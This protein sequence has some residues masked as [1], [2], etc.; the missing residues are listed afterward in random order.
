M[1][2]NYVGLTI[3]TEVLEKDGVAIDLETLEKVAMEAMQYYYQRNGERTCPEIKV[4]KMFPEAPWVEEYCVTPEAAL[5]IKLSTEPENYA[6]FNCWMEAGQ[7]GSREWGLL[8]D[9]AGHLSR[10]FP[11]LTF[12]VSSTLF[13]APDCPEDEKYTNLFKNGVLLEKLTRQQWAERYL[14]LRYWRQ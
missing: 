8:I 6:P 9:L 7:A 3:R 2:D 11:E 12:T 13:C 4:R 5:K 10:K 1:A 14:R